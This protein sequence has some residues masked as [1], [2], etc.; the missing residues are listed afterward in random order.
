MVLCGTAYINR[1]HASSHFRLLFYVT[2][3]KRC[4][5]AGVIDSRMF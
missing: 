1:F 3:S 5:M 2:S 4:N